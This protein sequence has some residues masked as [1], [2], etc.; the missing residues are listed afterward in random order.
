[1][2]KCQTY[3]FLWVRY[4]IG[5]FEVIRFP[6]IFPKLSSSSMTDTMALYLVYSR[7]SVLLGIRV[8]VD[9][10]YYGKCVIITSSGAF[11]FAFVGLDQPSFR[12][13]DW[14]L[15]VIL[16]SLTRFEVFFF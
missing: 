5:Y 3:V 4:K 7:P 9:K 2:T 14:I 10:A 12:S 11:H 13:I 16:I 1:M 8:L 15:G 6:Y